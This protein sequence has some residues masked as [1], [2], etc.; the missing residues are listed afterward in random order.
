MRCR[1][2][3]APV[4]C[5]RWQMSRWTKKA[6][7][8]SLFTMGGAGLEAEEEELNV[9]AGGA[10]PA[11]ET[12]TARRYR[13]RIRTRVPENPTHAHLFYVPAQPFSR[14]IYS[15][16]LVPA[17]YSISQLNYRSICRAMC[18]LSHSCTDGLI[19]AKNNHTA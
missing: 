5:T 9:P 3:I 17:Y 14:Q 15:S 11:P 2:S 4:E 6:R 16:V 19:S 10:R 13:S 7:R 12:D 18:C 1:I 8:R